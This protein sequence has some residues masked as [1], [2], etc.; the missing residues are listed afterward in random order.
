MNTY[1]DSNRSMK[2]CG[3]LLAVISFLPGPVQ[4]QSEAQSQ[5]QSEAPPQNRPMH[6]NAHLGFLYPLSTNGRLAAEYSNNFSIHLLMG[7]S[8]EETTFILS[9][10]SSVIKENASGVQFA[11][12]SNHV[13]DQT[14]GIQLAGVYNHT[15]KYLQGIQFAGTMNYAGRL[16]GLQFAGILNRAR[17]VQGIQFAGLINKADDVNGSQ[18]AGLINKAKNV[19]GFQFAGLINIADSS[20]Y[21]VAILNFIKQG[22]RSVGLSTDET[23]NLLASF[24]SGGRVLYGI[25][26]I[27]YNLKSGE[28]LYALGGGLGAHISFHE[29]FR[30]NAE[31]KTLM[32]E[33]FHRGEY[34]KHSLHL[35]PAW[36]VTDR[37]EIFAGPS[38]NYADTDMPEGKK[39]VSDPLWEK[40][41][42][43]SRSRLGY[44][45]GSAGIHFIL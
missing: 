35:L 11:G 10:I 3:L 21:P 28:S 43:G 4:A 31:L 27:G 8:R 5:A 30:L 22:Q 36:R 26:E 2:I 19:N 6:S 37:I 40:T 13:G 7:L 24:R 29:T 32:L 18:F 34:V 42:S 25:V 45:G 20:D 41:V 17:D 14:H 23:L 9:G 16:D 38:F 39:L 15:G 44:I 1:F 12:I 33:D